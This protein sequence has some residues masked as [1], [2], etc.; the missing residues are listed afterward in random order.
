[1]GGVRHTTYWADFTLRDLWDTEVNVNTKAQHNKSANRNKYNISN[2]LD[3]IMKEIKDK[4][5]I[6]YLE[7]FK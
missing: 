7:K 5:K 1:M 4:N 2:P 6:I 3:A